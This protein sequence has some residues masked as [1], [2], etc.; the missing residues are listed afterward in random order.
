[1]AGSQQQ[2][3]QIGTADSERFVLRLIILCL[4]EISVFPV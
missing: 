1:M 4:N 3:K 2:G